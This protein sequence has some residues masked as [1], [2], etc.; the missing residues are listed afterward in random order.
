[1]DWTS[2]GTYEVLV[3]PLAS[4]WQIELEGLPS[5]IYPTQTLAWKAAKA[6]ARQRAIEAVLYG[7][8]GHVREVHGPGTHRAATRSSS[9]RAGAAVFDALAANCRLEGLLK[10]VGVWLRLAQVST[11]QAPGSSP[12]EARGHRLP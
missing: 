3:R 2:D 10:P 7:R 9:G 12:H 6:L 5:R 4:G 8:D 11:A 1:V